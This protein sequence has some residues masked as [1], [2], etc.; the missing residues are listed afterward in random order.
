MDVDEIRLIVAEV[1]YAGWTFHVGEDGPRPYLQVQFDAPDLLSGELE[2]Q[3]GRKWWLSSHMTK[4]EIV[5]T[6]FKAVL[7]AVEHEARETFRYRGTAIFGPHFDV[8]RL[9][10]FARRRQNIDMRTGS[11][12][13]PLAQ[14]H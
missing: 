12:V 3:H 9:A 13:T 2:R 4:S 11:W 10:E 14:V 5:S 8:D 1:E 7:T 6:A